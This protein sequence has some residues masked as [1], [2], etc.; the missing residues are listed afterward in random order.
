MQNTVEFIG[1][2]LVPGSSVLEIGAGSCRIIAELVERYNIKGAG[3]DPFIAPAQRLGLECLRLRAEDLEG[4]E[5]QFDLIFSVHSL[6]HL[7]QPKVALKRAQQ[8]LRPGGR[9]LI[10]D[11][12]AGAQTGI[13]EHYFSLVE[14]RQMATEV[15]FQLDE[16]Y[17]QDDELIIVAH[18]G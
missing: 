6:H 1:R 2:Y 12:R 9:L 18:R 14:V 7:G 16:A 4:L 8:K 15:G 13:P 3:I 17:T 5:G 11:W 10:I